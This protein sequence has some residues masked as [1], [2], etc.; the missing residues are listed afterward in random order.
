MTDTKKFKYLTKEFPNN[1][2]GQKK[3]LQTI[4]KLEADGWDIVEETIQPGQFDGGS[5][6]CLFL[7][8]MPLAFFAYKNGRIVI[9]FRKAR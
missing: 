7:I 9:S 1:A 4:E 5:A 3:K 6:C 2:Y 8:C